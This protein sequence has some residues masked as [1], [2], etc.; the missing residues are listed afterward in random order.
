MG[1]LGTFFNMSW[2]SASSFLLST[3]L[4][5]AFAACWASLSTFTFTSAFEGPGS[6]DAILAHEVLLHQLRDSRNAI[7]AAT[8][9]NSWMSPASG[10][11]LHSSQA[12]KDL[13]TAHSQSWDVAGLLKTRGIP[14]RN[15][16]SRVAGL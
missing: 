5:S 7:L 14:N 15:L 10:L 9:S 1:Y 4:A 2:Y 6:V 11:Q 3:L 8:C 16:G 13:M 12:P